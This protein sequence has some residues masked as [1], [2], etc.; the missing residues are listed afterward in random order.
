MCRQ[1]LVSADAAEDLRELRA[2]LQEAQ[3]RAAAD[4]TENGRAPADHKVAAIFQR[5]R[6][7]TG[8]QPDKAIN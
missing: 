4:V 8:E 5:I 3:T 1:T 7:I 2:Q 6:A